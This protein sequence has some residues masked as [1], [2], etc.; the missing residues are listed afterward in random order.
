MA[1]TKSAG[2]PGRV[3]RSRFW[4]FC[5]KYAVLGFSK[6][7][8]R[9]RTEGRDNVPA[10]GPLLLVCN[11]ASYLDPPM[12]GITAGRWVGFL[13]QAGL[14]KFAP[15][16][17]WLAQVGVTLIDRNAPSKDAM[18][19]VAGCLASG[20]AVGIFPEGTRCADG[21]VGRFRSGV[22][23]LV[24]RTGAAV[25]PVGIEGSFRAFP[26]WAW[27]PRPRRIVLRYGEVW[28][29]ARVLEPGGVDRLRQRVAEL[30]KAPLAQMATLVPVANHSTGTSAA[31]TSAA[32][33]SVAGTSAAIPGRREETAAP[34]QDV[35]ADRSSSVS[36]SSPS[37]PSSSAGSEA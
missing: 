14:A 1:L 35:A 3:E 13:A 30:A 29:A 10:Q 11:H 9:L 21:A 25:V 31:G 27:L 6:I 28:P 22:E 19:L 16:R 24:R 17:W 4:W 12:I 23:F 33:T 32:G 5:S 2:D 8:F 15:L 18:R 7:Y 26:R 20:E 34:N 36:P 37:T